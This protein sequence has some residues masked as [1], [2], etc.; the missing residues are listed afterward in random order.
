M[1]TASFL[2]GEVV[3][4]ALHSTIDLRI[5]AELVKA[6][7][8]RGTAD[9]ELARDLRQVSSVLQQEALDALALCLESRSISGA[10]PEGR[11]DAALQIGERSLHDV[12]QLPHVP[13]P[14]VSLE[15]RVGL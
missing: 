2:I 13:G 14:A 10:Y 7:V 11:Y 9:A 8:E 5:D 4:Y 12:L 1:A 15:L 3:N 6:F